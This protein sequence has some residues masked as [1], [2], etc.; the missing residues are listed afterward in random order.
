MEK[1]NLWL[2][3][4]DLEHRK[5]G[6]TVVGR[7]KHAAYR[8]AMKISVPRQDGRI[9][10]GPEAV[11]AEAELEFPPNS[12]YPQ[13]GMATPSGLQQIMAALQ[14]AYGADSQDQTGTVL[15]KFESLYRG[16]ASLMDYCTAF[17]IRLEAA[18]EQAGLVINHVGQTHKFLKHAGL[19]EKFIDDIM[20]KV[21]GNRSR[22]EEIFQIVQRTAKHQQQHPD[23]TKGHIL[24]VDTDYGTAEEY[25]SV[26]YLTD[27]NG[28]WYIWDHN[29]S[30][31]YYLDVSTEEQQIWQADSWDYWDGAEA[32]EDYAD[33]ANLGLLPR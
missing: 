27:I 10:R 21:D 18:Q 3:L 23:E 29:L 1:L 13:G 19:T 15:D 14:E 24:L 30:A 12:A 22:F 32:E 2:M 17:K 33:D 6:P 5:V 31:G 8:L 26:E 16:N 20:L 28:V 7:L 25:P 9:L 11:A 4:T